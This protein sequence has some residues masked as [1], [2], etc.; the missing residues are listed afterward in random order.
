MTLLVLTPIKDETWPDTLT[1]L[2]VVHPIWAGNGEDDYTSVILEA[3]LCHMELCASAQER[4]LQFLEGFADDYDDIIVTFTI[5]E[6]ALEQVNKK[7]A[8]AAAKPN[9][10]PRTKKS[11]AT[12][13]AHEVGD[14]RTVTRES[15]RPKR[16]S[17]SSSEEQEASKAKKPEEKL[18]FAAAIVQANNL[19]SKTKPSDVEAIYKSLEDELGQFFPY[20]QD[21]L[22]CKIPAFLLRK[23]LSH[24]LPH[25]I[26][27][28][29]CRNALKQIIKLT[30]VFPIPPRPRNDYRRTSPSPLQSF[31]QKFLH[32]HLHIIGN[33]VNVNLVLQLVK[34]KAQI[35]PHLHHIFQILPRDKF[36]FIATT[37]H[38]MTHFIA[39]F[40]KSS[41]LHQRQRSL[42]IFFQA[43]ISGGVNRVTTI[44]SS[45]RRGGF[46]QHGT[47]LLDNQLASN[48]VA[49]SPIDAY[50]GQFLHPSVLSVELGLVEFD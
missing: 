6:A 33:Q 8:E 28:F 18:T 43:A 10:Q 2:V 22:P 15:S 27:S 47:S 31:K 19:T 44:Q 29:K 37:S 48:G 7:C 36:S 4:G 11:N 1:T 45:L 39:K 24:C 21:P 42:K 46:K 35:G 23:D 13:R 41:L 25:R 40:A 49:E 14:E 26:S 32:C 20:G 9:K 17:T 34:L 30:K 5:V 16:K 38:S 3:T 50:K 12:P